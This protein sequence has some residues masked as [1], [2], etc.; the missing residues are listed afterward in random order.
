MGNTALIGA[1]MFLFND[2]EICN[3]IL[4]N[5]KHINLE[6]DTDFQDTYID[7]LYF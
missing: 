4:V 1:K 6:E 3:H 2:F 5:C 7:K